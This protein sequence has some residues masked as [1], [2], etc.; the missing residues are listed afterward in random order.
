VTI[1]DTNFLKNKATDSDGGLFHVSATTSNLIKF[2]NV[3]AGPFTVEVSFA[4]NNG[5]IFYM[6]SNKN[7]LTMDQK[8]KIL[9]SKAN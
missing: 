9:I 3:G 7:T 5:G 6:N 1:I 8:T 4:G 2:Q